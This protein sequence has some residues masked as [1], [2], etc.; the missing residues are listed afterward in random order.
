[1]K[2][3]GTSCILEVHALSQVSL[4]KEVGDGA[5]SSKKASSAHAPGA[6]QLPGNAQS[7]KCNHQQTLIYRR[8]AASPS[9]GDHGLELCHPSRQCFAHYIDTR[10]RDL[11]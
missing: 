6:P 9:W 1:M 7:G 5:V 4:V 8:A 11:L 2:R 3:T 10:V